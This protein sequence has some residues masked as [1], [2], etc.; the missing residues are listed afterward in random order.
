MNAISGGIWALDC[1]PYMRLYSDKIICNMIKKFD[2]ILFFTMICGRFFSSYQKQMASLFLVFSYCIY[3]PFQYVCHSINSKPVPE[4]GGLDVGR[5][6]VH[7]KLSTDEQTYGGREAGVLLQDL[8]WLLLNDE[9][10]ANQKEKSN[11]KINKKDVIYIDIFGY[12]LIILAE[13]SL[14]ISPGQVQN[15]Q[16]FGGSLVSVKS[17]E[18]VT[19]TREQVQKYCNWRKEALL[20]L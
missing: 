11:L 19:S 16:T 12:Y 3:H 20:R 18:K 7:I 17:I 10:T 15:Y 5:V 13:S 14:R 1:R 6:H 8:G 9:G 2:L 4:Y